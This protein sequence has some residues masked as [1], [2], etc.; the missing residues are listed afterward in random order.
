MAA[1][2][3]TDARLYGAVTTNG[4]ENG[5]GGEGG[6]FAVPSDF[7]RTIEEAVLGEQSLVSRLNPISCSSN[8]IQVPVDENSHPAGKFLA[9]ICTTAGGTGICSATVHLLD[10]SY[11]SA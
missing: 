3:K 9:V 6:G 1:Y 11:T 2:G 7:R 10:P 5:P 4:N 8:Q